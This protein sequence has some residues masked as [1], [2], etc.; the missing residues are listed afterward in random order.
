MFQE[1]ENQKWKF[2]H[3]LQIN[4]NQTPCVGRNNILNTYYATLQAN[5]PM[6][7]PLT[8][9]LQILKVLPLHRLLLTLPATVATFLHFLLPDFPFFFAGLLFKSWASFLQQDC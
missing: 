2:A 4:T 7:M 9:F 5:L 1:F 6:R 8:F 3:L